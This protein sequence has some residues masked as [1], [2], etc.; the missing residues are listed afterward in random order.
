MHSLTHPGLQAAVSILRATA[1]KAHRAGCR[2]LPAFT[3]PAALPNLLQVSLS[4]HNLVQQQA[5]NR[6]VAGVL[7]TLSAGLVAT[8]LVGGTA[9][10]LCLLGPGGLLF[11]PAVAPAAFSACVAGGGA[12]GLSASYFAGQKTDQGVA[13]KASAVALHDAHQ[14]AQ[15]QLP[16]AVNRFADAMEH[17]AKF[18]NML[19]DSV[20]RIEDT[21]SRVEARLK[22]DV[23]TG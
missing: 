11:A 5:K 17:L 13:L 22:E 2:V 7:K 19:S 6:K 14:A 9:L 21:A 20:Q 8:G 3:F 4:V 18:F 12:A 16:N 10:A 23:L 1:Q 15:Q